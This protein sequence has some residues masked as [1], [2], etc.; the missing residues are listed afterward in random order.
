M[1]DYVDVAVSPAFVPTTSGG[2]AFNTNGPQPVFHAVWTDNRDVRQPAAGPNGKVDWSKYTPPTDRLGQSVFD[3]AQGMTVC[4]P[5]ST[6]SRNQNIY[7]ARLSTG[8]VVGS[9]GNTKPLSPTVQRAFVVFAQN[10]S[11]TTKSFR[12]TIASQPTVR[13]SFRQFDQ[14]TSI[15]DDKPY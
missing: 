9:P 13:A 11:P 12:M 4:D 10:T 2:W 3:P 8:L 1:G 15:V 7:T 14:L 5:N 6:G